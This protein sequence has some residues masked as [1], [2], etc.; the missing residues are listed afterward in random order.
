[1]LQKLYHGS[2]FEIKKPVFGKGKPYNDYGLGFYCTDTVEMAKEWAVSLNRDGFANAYQIDTNGLS[3]LDLNSPPYGIL[4]WLTVLLGN[5]QFD[6][7]SPLA[8]DARSYLTKTMISSQDTAQTIPI[9]R[10]HRILL[11]AP[12]LIGS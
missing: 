2:Q 9:F 10:L 3:V 7:P 1:M 12:F 5:R 6:I 11:T 4:H 8:R